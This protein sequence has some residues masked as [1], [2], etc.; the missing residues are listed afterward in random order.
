MGGWIASIGSCNMGFNPRPFG[1]VGSIML[2]GF[3]VKIVKDKNPII[4]IC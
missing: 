1:G 2:K 3:E 4:I